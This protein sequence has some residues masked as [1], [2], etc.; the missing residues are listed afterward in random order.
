MKTG[1]DG[2]YQFETI[3]PGPYK[4]DQRTWRTPHIHYKVHAR[5]HKT[6]TTQLFFEG[7]PYLHADPFRKP[8]LTIPLRA[9][10]AP[11]APYWRGKFDIVLAR[12]KHAATQGLRGSSD[13]RRHSRKGPT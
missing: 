9:V 4:M 7:A 12:R 10:Q 2:R 13:G 5:A 3:Y 6:L 11:E 1:K 8:S